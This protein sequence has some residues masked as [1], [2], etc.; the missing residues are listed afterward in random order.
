MAD[1]TQPP[2]FDYDSSQHELL[3]EYRAHNKVL[4]EALKCVNTW[5]DDPNSLT[6]EEVSQLQRQIRT[7]LQGCNYEF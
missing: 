6:V 1:N 2:L 4:K 3:V 7:L 5:L